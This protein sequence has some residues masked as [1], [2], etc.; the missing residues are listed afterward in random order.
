MASA[1]RPKAMDGM[2][3][4]NGT[5]GNP[6]GDPLAHSPG[7]NNTSVVVTSVQSSSS[8]QHHLVAAT[9][10]VQ[11]TLPTHVT[12]NNTTIP[13]N[14][15][16]SLKREA[17]EDFQ[18]GDNEEVLGAFNKKRFADL[19]QSP[20][21][22]MQV[23]CTVQLS[24]E[25][26]PELLTNEKIE[27]PE[28]NETGIVKPGTSRSED[29]EFMNVDEGFQLLN[30]SLTL[31]ETLNLRETR[32]VED[33]GMK[34]VRSISE[35]F[36]GKTGK[37]PLQV[38]S[39]IQANQQSV[40]QTP[41]NIQPVQLQKGNVILVSKP[42]SVIHTTQGSLQTLQVA[43]R[44]LN[45]SYHVVVDPG[46]D[47]SLSNEDDSTKKRRDILTRRPSYRKI[48]ND[49]GGGEIA[50][51]SSMA[52]LVLTDS[53]QL[54]SDTQ[55]LGIYSSPM[56]S[57]VLT[58]SSQLNSDGFENC[59]LSVSTK[60][61]MGSLYLWTKR[62][63]RCNY[64]CEHCITS[65]WGGSVGRGE[66]SSE[67]DTNEDSELSSHSIP[68]HY[69]THT[70][71]P[72]GAIQISSQGETVQGLH[73]LTMT[74]ATTAGGAIVQYAQGQDGQFFVPGVIPK[75]YHQ[76]YKTLPK[77]NNI[78][79]C[80]DETDEDDEVLSVPI[81]QQKRVK[82][83]LDYGSMARVVTQGGGITGGPIIAEDQARKR[84][85]RLLKNSWK[86]GLHMLLTN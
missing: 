68:S 59:E 61:A 78:Q 33:M 49:L 11:L 54:T 22:R 28:N 71:I 57:L 34:F 51:S 7:D 40:I 56:A 84:E 9:S 62:S 38:Q 8:Q 64:L 77:K 36:L 37:D 67:C 42:N 35:N 13:Q 29:P 58:D 50:G 39:V 32:K 31:I 16:A 72:A 47:D 69:Q 52:S 48:L 25:K 15:V 24:K 21:V 6:G 76:E 12:N 85:M 5:T 70:V 60:E 82:H 20:Q 83:R 2:V 18:L 74:N 14:L 10:I 43:T 41:A 3:E 44:P 86:S 73:T 46:S 55:H 80:L 45:G 63:L 19:N 4:E 53:S 27:P 23:N 81:S 66:S 65:N 17:F 75:R 26:H 30:A 79:D 1:L